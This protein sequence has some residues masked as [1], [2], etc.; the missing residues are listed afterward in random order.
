MRKFPYDNEEVHN[1]FGNG[2]DDDDSGDDD[3][4]EN[5]DD[6]EE[7]ISID[8]TNISVNQ[9]VMETALRVA[10]KTWGWFFMSADKKLSLVEKIYKKLKVLFLEQEE[11]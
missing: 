11:M 2:G 4:G 6:Y 9:K 8:L 7:M 3:D 10:E 5:Y 1:F